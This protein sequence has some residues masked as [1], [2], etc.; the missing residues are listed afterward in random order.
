MILAIYHFRQARLKVEKIE[1]KAKIKSINGTNLGIAEF[2][3]EFNNYIDKQNTSN[4]I[5]NIIQGVGYL[6]AAATAL[7]S[8]FLS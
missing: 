6:S 3:S 5:I 1:S 7:F 8:F 4:R 2:I